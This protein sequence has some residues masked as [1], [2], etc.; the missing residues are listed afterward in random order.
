[1]SNKI[2]IYGAG[3]CG[4]E[5]YNELK[6]SVHSFCDSSE[7]KIGTT[8]CSLPV[9]SPNELTRY[10][11]CVILICMNDAEGKKVEEI[12]NNKNICNVITVQ[13]WRYFKL[14]HCRELERIKKDSSNFICVGEGKD[15]Y[16]S[17]LMF[18]FL[19]KNAAA[20]CEWLEIEK[21]KSFSGEIIIINQQYHLAYCEKINK[22]KEGQTNYEIIDLYKSKGFGHQDV[23]IVEA[24]PIE[25]TEK[26][27]RELILENMNLYNET[28][29]RYVSVVG[30]ETPIFKLIEIETYNRCNG[31]CSF[32]PVNRNDDT[33]QEALMQES[34]FY[35]IINE[36]EEMDYSGSISLFSNNEPLLDKRIIGFHKYA[37]EH[38]PK[39]RIHMLTNGTLLTKEIF[40]NLI[41]NLD[42]LI[43]DNYSQN[44][45]LIKPVKE[46]SQIVANDRKLIDKVT[47]FKRRPFE[48]LSSRGGNAKNRK[49]DL[50][51]STTRCI[52]P[53][54]Q[55]VVRPT[56]EVSLCCNDPLGKYT[57]GDLNQQ[58]L[59]EVWYG[60]RFMEARCKLSQGRG[61][62]GNCK[63]CDSLHIYN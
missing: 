51:M 60:S 22:L 48:V 63:D 16:I 27:W 36:L 46:I 21:I 42:E 4:K 23:L 47:I 38:L 57:M 15:L 5:E 37:R 20:Y 35:K 7:L 1:M 34:L 10:K 55:M 54:Q 2:I 56:G 17:K 50:D 19:K 41:D 28:V 58:S 18:A 39:A 14:L 3:I 49:N 9:I 52:Y 25:S 24:N 31:V 12:L 32:C 61:L 29:E 40:N 30:E 53:F 33:R 43:I 11:D 26:E 59:L 62:Y 6:D 44:L 45:N 8:F 13:E